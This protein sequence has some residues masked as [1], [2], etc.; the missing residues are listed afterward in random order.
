MVAGRDPQL[1]AIVSRS[2]SVS[3]TACALACGLG[4]LLGGWLAVARFPG[5]GALLAVLN[6]LLALPSRGFATVNAALAIMA[7]ALAWAVGRRYQ[8]LAAERTSRSAA[9]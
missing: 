2:V 9:A 6:T 5:R 7:L 3:A 8:A 1:M 4:L